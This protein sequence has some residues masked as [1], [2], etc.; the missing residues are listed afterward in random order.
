M[1]II[2]EVGE[3]EIEFPDEMS[4][5]EIQSVLQKHYQPQS[6][7]LPIP[8]DA[9]MMAP[10]AE[11]FL[12]SPSGQA[13]TMVGSGLE[14]I[15]KGL[16]YAGNVARAIPADVSAFA[17]MF[18]RPKDKPNTLFPSPTRI[19]EAVRKNLP[20][21]A[22]A[23][24]NVP[25]AVMNQPMPIDA[26]IQEAALEA[27]QR[28]EGSGVA[29]TAHL[30][31]GLAA[32]APLIAGIAAIPA[33]LRF[34]ASAGFSADM[35]SKAPELFTQYAEEINKPKEEQDP[36]AVAELQSGIIQTFAFAPLAGAHGAKG[37]KDR[38]NLARE[39]AVKAPVETAVAEVAKAPDTITTLAAK[40][41]G[42]VT[43]EEMSK[44]SDADA[45]ALFDAQ[46]KAGNANQNDGVRAGLKLTADDIPQLEKLRNEAM[47]KFQEH[48]K[49]GDNASYQGALGKVTWLNGAIEGAKKSGPNY[50]EVLSQEGR[51]IGESIGA[52]FD[53]EAMGMWNFTTFD[54]AGNPSTSFVVKAGSTPETVTAKYN[55]IRDNF[56]GS[57]SQPR[58]LKPS[59]TN[60]PKEAPPVPKAEMGV[61]SKGRSPERQKLLD[62]MAKK[63]REA[64][65]TQ[66]ALEKPPS[67]AN[68]QTRVEP[69]NAAGVVGETPSPAAK[70]VAEMT[71]RE[72]LSSATGEQEPMSVLRQHYADMMEAYRQRKPINME[73][74]S[75][76]EPDVKGVKNMGEWLHQRGYRANQKTGNWVYFGE[77]AKA[78]AAERFPILKPGSERAFF[79]RESEMA[80]PGGTIPSDIGVSTSELTQLAQATPKV[81]G[82]SQSDVGRS[83]TELLKGAAESIKSSA[84]KVRDFLVSEPTWDNYTEA[85][86]KWQALRQESSRDAYLAWKDFKGKMPDKNRRAAIGAWVDAGGDKAVMD[87]AAS[88]LPAKYAE[89]YKQAS[90]LTPEE[91]VFAKN[92]RSYFDKRLQDAQDAGILENGLENYIRRIYEK[93]PKLADAY[94]SELQ[95]LSTATPDFARQRFYEYDAD[96]IK[97]G[98]KPIQDFA[99]RVLEY[100][101]A[102]NHAIADRAFVKAQMKLKMPDGR[103]RIDVGGSGKLLPEGDVP[104]DALLIKPQFKPNSDAP[105]DN[106]SDYRPFNHPAFRK[107]K[108]LSKDPA[109]RDVYVQGDVLVHPD[110]LPQ[111]QKLLEASKIRQHPIGRGALQVSSTI[112]QTMLDL[113]LFHPVQIGVHGMEHRVNPLRLKE[114]NLKDP[115]QKA[116]VEHGLVVAEDRGFNDWSE[117]LHGTSLTRHIPGLGPKLQDFHNWM[118]KEWIPTIKMNMAEHAL[119]RNRARYPKLTEDQVMKLTAEQANAAFGGLNYRML[120]RSQTMQD[121]LRLTF[122]APDFL[123]ARGRFAGQAMKGFG[124]EQMQ[125]LAL[126]AATLYVTARIANQLINDNPHW[127]KENAFNIIYNDHAYGLRT[128]QG[129]LLHLISKPGQFWYHRLNPTVTRPLM[130][131]ISGRDYFG[132]QV[133]IGDVLLDELKTIIPISLRG[134]FE[135]KEQ[136]MFESALNAMGI[137][138]RRYNAITQA[139][140]LARKWREESK[141]RPEPG[142][143]IYD[144]EKDPLR[145]LK[146]SLQH[147]HTPDAVKEISDLV[148][149]GAYTVPQLREHFKRY[150][151]SQFAGSKKNQK[152]F[153]ASLRPDQQEIVRLAQE[154]KQKTFEDFK[155]AVALYLASASAP[156]PKPSPPGP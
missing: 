46:R 123:E 2:V 12:R 114:I 34:L 14:A 57:E 59:S 4:S 43:I 151:E 49:A 106:R 27:Q 84:Q 22:Q 86:G 83:A 129:D 16:E 60:E 51:T 62:D 24:G 36:N 150:A 20:F 155:A 91:V 79:P 10:P 100:D 68:A 21:V 41:P 136:N 113:S 9:M 66:G 72:V 69:S 11:P 124:K 58:P 147:E 77:K 85:L 26:R 97:A 149:S 138:T 70:P 148:Q 28:G 140:D 6:K 146:L 117:G 17:S 8:R 67:N 56:E 156:P 98:K 111:M 116:L 54:K 50:A 107:Y 3:D 139:Y 18:E 122:L 19:A 96:A 74:A 112:K 89:I 119:E 5:D 99:A 105:L 31:Q 143:F 1:P 40:K 52:K 44:L 127:E 154:R 7:E 128:V 94:S 75:K 125:A 82:K 133:G 53:G 142:E 102:L 131:I 81:K 33:G 76:Y 152:A 137:T 32:T 15:S 88:E 61:D 145:R 48:F 134:A 87:K 101:Q 25:A 110:A 120:G 13:D 126:G 39:N 103:P 92:I 35:I 95:H 80:G 104:K 153:M 63:V 135:G 71:P 38:L 45:S 30:S 121:F 115:Q 47:D 144:P 37:I 42:E 73:A 23:A 108:W 109:G 118:F 65:L 130:E 29:T 64:T 132:R 78:E 93:D 55:L 141:T 90:N